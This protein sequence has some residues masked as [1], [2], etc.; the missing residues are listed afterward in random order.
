MRIAVGFD[1]A[2]F[3]LKADVLRVVGEL[4]HAAKDFGTNSTDPVDY[5]DF[6]RAVA[7]AVS[8]GDCERGVVVCGSG[9]G[10]SVAAT[11]VTG[12]RSALCHDTFS[13][14]QGVED[15]DMNV[16][17]LGARVIGPS[18]AAEVLRAFLAAKFSNAER[19][20]RRLNKVKQIEA[21]ARAGVFDQG[22]VR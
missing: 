6:A 11:K 2:G 10:A 18:L 12:I 4:G 13:A 20:V 14:R 9:V 5:P 21:D 7:V 19:H 17:C 16:L 3:P 22:G 15:D 8:R 1:H